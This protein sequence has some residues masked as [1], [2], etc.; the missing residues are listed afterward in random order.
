MHLQYVRVGVV[1]IFCRYFFLSSYL[2]S[3]TLSLGDD[4]IQT[5][6]LSQRAV[7][8]KATTPP[9]QKKKMVKNIFF[10]QKSQ[11]SEIFENLF[12][13]SQKKKLFCEKLI[14]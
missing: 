6:I 14:H 12:L 4:P 2:S 8:P 7:K 5:E 9:P 1:W 11:L 10:Y 3:F 13:G